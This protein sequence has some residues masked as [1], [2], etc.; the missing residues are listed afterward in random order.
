MYDHVKNSEHLF[1]N[2]LWFHLSTLFILQLFIFEILWS[3]LFDFHHMREFYNC[4]VLS[5]K[6]DFCMLHIH[7]FHHFRVCYLL[8]TI[9]GVTFRRCFHITY[10]NNNSKASYKYISWPIDVHT[11]F[12]PYRCHI[13]PNNFPDINLFESLFFIQMKINL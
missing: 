4:W 7:H 3:T 8:C 9:I 13:S 2:L 1:S 12:L 6:S 5:S 10:H 11:H